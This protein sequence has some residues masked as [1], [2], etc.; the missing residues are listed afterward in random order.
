[1]ARNPSIVML[2]LALLIPITPAALTLLQIDL[3]GGRAV[4]FGS[5][6]LAAVVILVLGYRNGW[7]RTAGYL[8]I[9]L[10]G[11]AATLALINAGPLIRFQHLPGP[12]AILTAGDGWLLTILAIQLLFVLFG[13]FRAVPR[14]R[15]LFVAPRW[16]YLAFASFFVIAGAALSRDLLTYTAELVFACVL[17]AMHLF[18][19]LLAVDSI[20]ARRLEVFRQ[21]WR[22]LFTLISDDIAPS[23]PRLDRPALLAA[24]WVTAVAGVLSFTVYDAHP[25]VPD[26]VCYYL[27]ARYFAAG[28]ISLPSPPVPNAF[29]FYLMQNN[30]G[31]WFSCFPPGWPLVLSI[32]VLVGAPWL[33]NPVLAGFCTLGIYL[34]IWQ[35][36]NRSI[37]RRSILL[38]CASP[39][40]LFMGM[41]WMA[42]MLTLAAALAA[43]LSLL[44]AR[45]HGPIWCVPAGA[46]VGLVALIRPY[47]GLIL[48]ALLLL[49]VI[50]WRGLHRRKIAILVALVISQA[51]FAALVFPY[52]QALTGRA[53]QFPVEDY[54][55]KKFGPGA[56]SIGFG[57][58]HGLS[59]SIDALPGHSPVEAV[60]N[61]VL[62]LS[63]MNADLFGWACGSLVLIAAA[64][65]AGA[66]DR[67]DYP[68]LVVIFAIP[69]AY[70]LYWYSG[71]PDFGARYWFLTIVPLAALTAR[72]LDWVTARLGKLF[73]DAAPRVL[74]V[75]VALC[76]MS[77]VVYIPWRS[78]DKYHSYLRMRPD[79]R[80]LKNASFF[81]NGLVFIR[82]E[83]HP[84]YASAI[85]Y[86]PLDWHDSQPLFVLDRGSEMR[87]ELVKAF[88]DRPVWVIDGPSVTGRG[89]E[90]VTTPKNTALLK[91]G[92]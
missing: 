90:I 49:W 87:H 17:H 26:E 30:A 79:L 28:Q 54:F 67:R 71:G 68:M 15:A 22:K 20:D 76:L 51:A 29:D 89:Y 21:Q 18:T 16:R 10:I 83:E 73:P 45:S 27:Q 91:R 74:A 85:V 23:S 59:W 5:A 58:N 25:H 80:E 47:D 56:N 36:Y 69:A 78:A 31:R 55:N 57:P 39:W 1:L 72:S 2:A 34:L 9:S 7:T 82:G 61:T 66:F 40:F 13:V 48:G 60:I 50:C 42:H 19:I 81:G 37:A 62:N 75:M 12:A 65:I 88:P 8:A 6:L 46:A 63:L 92:R 38:L 43:A 35:L 53:L 4:Y 11:E 77:I 84:D 44:R 86:N 24:I 41:N 64:F 14:W 3:S 32:G 52:N 33:V 70:G